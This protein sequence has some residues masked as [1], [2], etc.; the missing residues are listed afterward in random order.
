MQEAIEAQDAERVLVIVGRGHKYFLDELTREAGYRWVDPRKWLPAPHADAETA[1]A[2]NRA[3][4][5]ASSP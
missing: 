1:T 5:S 2:S 4:P 3:D